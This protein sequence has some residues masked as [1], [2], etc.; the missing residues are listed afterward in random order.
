V[1]CR[2]SFSSLAGD[3]LDDDTAPESVDVFQCEP[4][5]A[6]VAEWFSHQREA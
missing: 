4:G 3:D 6:E 1:R 2:I 5:G